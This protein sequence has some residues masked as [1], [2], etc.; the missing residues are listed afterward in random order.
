MTTTKNI[1]IWA[2]FIPER[3]PILLSVIGFMSMVLRREEGP[4]P[5]IASGKSR[6]YK[7][8][9]S[10]QVLKLPELEHYTQR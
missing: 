8:R 2:R 4:T 3:C 9:G 1:K 6:T 10:F 5:S 7:T